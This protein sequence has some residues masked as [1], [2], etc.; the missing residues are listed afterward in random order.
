[1]FDY[2]IL[3]C[4]SENLSLSLEMKIDSLEMSENRSLGKWRSLIGQLV[5]SAYGQPQCQWV[6]SLFWAE[7]GLY[8]SLGSFFLHLQNFFYTS[9]FFLNSQNTLWPFK[10][11]R[12][13]YT[14]KIM[15]TFGSQNIWLP[16]VKI[17]HRKS[18]SES[19]NVLPEVDF[20]K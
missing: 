18:T 14:S 7:L 3:Y 2:F 11:I 4:W 8:S 19:Q 15:S 12:R 16:E 20:Q 13:H 5:R 6:K 9:K 10:K 1:M 17:Y